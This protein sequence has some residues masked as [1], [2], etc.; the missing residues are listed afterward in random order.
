MTPT[1]LRQLWSLIETTQSNLLLKLD[2]PSL[3][4]WLLK[5]FKQQRA[6]N[7]EET[8]ILSDYLSNRLSLIREMA[9]Q[10]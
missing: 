9:E 1:M 8:N 5:Q 10:R 7:H 4:Q 3:V 6:L 2:D